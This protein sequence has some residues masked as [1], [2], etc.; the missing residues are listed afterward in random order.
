MGLASGEFRYNVGGETNN[1]VGCDA[2]LFGE[3]GVLILCYG[4]CFLKY[5]RNII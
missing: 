1:F 5:I 4:L 2:W 3:S